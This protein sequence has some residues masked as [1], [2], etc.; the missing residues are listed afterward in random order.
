MWYF[1][2]IVTYKVDEIREKSTMIIK[3]IV[4]LFLPFLFL[5]CVVMP[6]YNDSLQQYAVDRSPQVN[7]TDQ[8]TTITD[9]DSLKS[10]NIGLLYSD[11]TKETIKILTTNFPRYPDVVSYSSL[12]M[13][14]VIY[15]REIFR[16]VYEINSLDDIRAQKVDLI[17]LLDIQVKMGQAS[18]Q[19][20]S[21]SISNYFI[22]HNKNLC[23]EITASGSARVPWPATTLGFSSAA[24]QAISRLTDEYY[25]NLDITL[26]NS[27]GDSSPDSELHNLDKSKESSSPIY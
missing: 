20:T 19:E 15:L 22:D 8:R 2:Q 9:I 13:M 1:T 27:R 4:F 7:D 17:L 26:N 11:N 18:G 25:Q 23:G 24:R 10:L 5:S 21:V 12:D 16:H 14:T 6:H 3:R